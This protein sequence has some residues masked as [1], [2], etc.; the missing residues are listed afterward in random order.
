MRIPI[1][2]VA[3]AILALCLGGCAT[4]RPASPGAAPATPAQGSRPTPPASPT[5]PAATPTRNTINFGALAYDTSTGAWGAS[6]DQASQAAADRRA[7]GECQ[8]FS[9]KCLLVVRFANQCAA[10]AQGASA[11]TSG[12]G[13]A[14]AREQAERLALDACGKR[15]KQCSVRLWGCTAR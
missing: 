9:K 4:E 8:P 11:K 1:Y 15:G 6:Y 14:S 5:P 10:Y 13:R 12:T 3:P 7:L 2:R